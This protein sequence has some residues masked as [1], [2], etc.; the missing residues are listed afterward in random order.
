MPKML[1]ITDL[2]VS[3]EMV[4]KLRALKIRTTLGLF[5]RTARKRQRD[6][7]AEELE[8]DQAELLRLTNLAD[9][10][11]LHGV[12]PAYAFVLYELVG[13]VRE[14]RNRNPAHLLAAIQQSPTF[15]KRA[16]AQPALTEVQGWIDQAKQLGI[17]IS[18]R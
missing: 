5:E 7:L 13:T 8:I 18:Y 4:G 14:L 10:L 2:E 6:R 12:G 9:F 15:R 11:R 1:S 17:E 16:F 3:P